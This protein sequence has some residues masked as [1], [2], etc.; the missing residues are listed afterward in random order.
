MRRATLRP[1][2]V[3]LLV[4]SSLWGQS[5]TQTTL[6]NPPVGASHALLVTLGIGDR[7]ETNWDGRLEVRHG[8]LVELIGYEMGLGDVIHPPRR[9]QMSTRPAFAFN[10]CE[11]R[12]RSAPMG[13]P[14]KQFGG[15][16]P[17]GMV[18]VA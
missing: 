18:S 4:T 12:W 13:E 1:L 10:Q 15:Y 11:G 16:R 17:D 9:W 5:S 2:V 6:R 14:E 8:E 3:L 7:Q